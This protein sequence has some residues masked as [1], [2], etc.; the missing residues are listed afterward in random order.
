MPKATA[1]LDLLRQLR[2]VFKTDAEAFRRKEASAW[3]R[4]EK[5]AMAGQAAAC[6]YTVE[7]ID[8]T[9]RDWA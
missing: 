2:E 9:L 6:E 5:Q 3:T 4:L 7:R 8:A 1:P